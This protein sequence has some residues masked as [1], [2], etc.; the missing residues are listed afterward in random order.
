MKM[1]SKE[2]PKTKE[3]YFITKFKPK[4]NQISLATKKGPHRPM[5]IINDVIHIIEI[6]Q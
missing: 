4:L 5:G 1:D 6:Q 3:Q 2:L